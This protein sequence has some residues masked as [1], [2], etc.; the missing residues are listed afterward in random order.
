[1]SVRVNPDVLRWARNARLLSVEQ[2]A[3]RL[4]WPEDKIV[5][6]E[7]ATEISLEEL[8]KLASGYR[9]SPATLLMPEPLPADRYPPRAIEDFRLHS[10]IEAEPL[11][12]ETQLKVENAFEVIVLLGDVNDE[13]VNVAPRPLLPTA[14]TMQDPERVA[15]RERERIG[16]A[17]DAQLGWEAD[18][19]AFLRWREVVE[20]QDIIVHKTPLHEASVRGFAIFARGYG[21]MAIDSADD[22]RARIFTLFHEYGHL[23][24]RRSGISDQNRRVK[25]ERWCNQ[26]AAAFLMP[27]E[28]FRLQYALVCPEGP[29]AGEGQVRKMANCF[30]VSLSAVAI[31]FEE[32]GLAPVGFYNRLKVDWK[33]RKPRKGGGPSDL[34][35]A[36]IELGR[37]GTTQV[38]AISRALDR[39]LIDQLE[40]HYAL[41]VPLDHLPALTAAA[42]VR[43][44][45][46]G[47]TR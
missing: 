47:P 29:P 24:L 28:A 5:E 33:A 3:A 27:A 34:S 8:D 37:L 40:A 12:F 42:R 25:T 23:L 14:D 17:I 32:L 13:D 4:Q 15:T 10:H 26:F 19:E 7:Q 9:L 38:S 1:V 45:A 35:Q 21:L 30:N 6:V 36:D 43:L 39:G 2:A 20:A 22:Y 31:R 16:L 46:Y 11:S 41:G 18:K 44:K